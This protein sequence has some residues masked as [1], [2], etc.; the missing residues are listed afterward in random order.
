MFF[1][2]VKNDGVRFYPN[3]HL[4]FKNRLFQVQSQVKSRYHYSNI[5]VSWVRQKWGEKCKNHRLYWRASGTYLHLIPLTPRHFS[6]SPG[7]MSGTSCLQLAVLT[8]ILPQICRFDVQNVKLGKNR[9]PHFDGLEKTWLEP[10]FDVSNSK[11]KNL[12]QLCFLQKVWKIALL[13]APS[14]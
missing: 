10:K 14:E 12:A 11:D 5:F 2:A 4:E 3:W 9:P 8:C 1:Q 6:P 7:I 13:L